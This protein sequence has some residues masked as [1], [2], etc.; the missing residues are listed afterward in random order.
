MSH[1]HKKFTK[2]VRVNFKNK[3]SKF[4]GPSWSKNGPFCNN[5]FFFKNWAPSLFSKHND[6]IECKISKKENS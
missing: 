6:V 4:L 1:H 5:K 2:I 3:A